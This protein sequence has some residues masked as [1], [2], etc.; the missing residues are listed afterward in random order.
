MGKVSDDSII[1]LTRL[2][3]KIPTKYYV[4]CFDVWMYQNSGKKKK[5]IFD[6]LTRGPLKK[7]SKK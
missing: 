4:R 2:H 3:Y 5:I 7:V 1:V 6:L